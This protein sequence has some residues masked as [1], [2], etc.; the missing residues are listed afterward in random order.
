MAAPPGR[1]SSVP[2]LP[3]PCPKSP[4]AYP[5]LYGK[6]R[7]VAKVQMLEREIGFLQVCLKFFLTRFLFLFVLFVVVYVLDLFVNALLMLC[8]LFFLGKIKMRLGDF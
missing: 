1:S 5:D 3:P 4:P 7:E 8:F 2:S 6:R